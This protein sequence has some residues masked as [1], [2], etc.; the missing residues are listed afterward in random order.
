LMSDYHLTVMLEPAVDSLQIQPDGWYI[1]ATIGGGGHTQAMLDRGARVLGLDQDSQ[2][3]AE[4]RRRLGQAITDQ[5]LVLAQANFRDLT[6]VA[7]QQGL[8]E[9]AGI[10]MDLGVS[11]WQL[12]SRE[13]GFGFG[14]DTLDM[15]MDTS[16]TVTAADVVAT[17]PESD[18]AK[19]LADLGEERYAKRLAR[20]ITEQRQRQPITSGAQLAE[21]ISRHS[22]A[23]YRYGR[24]HPATRTFQAL[25]LA[26]NDEL[27]SL[28]QALPQA[29]QL[30]QPAGR[31]AVIS[32]HSLEDRMI[33]QF[34]QKSELLTPITPSPILPS[35]DEIS[36][37]SRSRSAKLRVA[38]RRAD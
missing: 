4:V 11:S 23:A 20:A 26:V 33:K 1:D 30:L 21:V 13:R 12:N 28:Q 10:L 2:A 5:R 19:L 38:E 14:S 6:D 18:L 32:F 7:Q 29:V 16:Q 8:T 3:L 22:P 27:G 9:V 17:L 25:R 36:Q 37:N 31:L 15:R 35:P 34:F 24:I